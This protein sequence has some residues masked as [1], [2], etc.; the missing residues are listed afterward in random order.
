MIPVFSAP[1]SEDLAPFTAL[2]WEYEIPHRV[3]EEDDKQVLLVSASIDPGKVRSLY[4]YWKDGG[5]LHAVEIRRPVKRQRRFGVQA[6][7]PSRVPV[8]LALIGLSVLATLLISFGANDSWMARLT[9][10][11]YLVDGHSLRYD[12][13]LGM[14]SSGQWWRLVTPI[15][16]HF[17]VL[18]ILFNLLWVWVVGQRV[19]LLQGGKA[20]VALTLVSGVASNLAQYLIS[21]PMFGGMSGVV[22]GLLAYTWIW[23]RFETQSRFGFPPALMALMVLWL[24]LG[25]TGVLEGAGMG[26]IANT[27]HLVGLLAGLAWYPIGRLF[28]P[29]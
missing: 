25:Y 4:Q 12:S 18:H 2:L 5:D 10:T 11:N 24:A 19:E 1:L 22:F 20:L 26:A 16:L 14:L 27:A 23:D 21:G 29:R 13:I 3:I 7:N 17:S 9:F 8:T 6:V 15:F 28:G